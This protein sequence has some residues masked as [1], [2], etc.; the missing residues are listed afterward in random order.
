MESGGLSLAILAADVA[1][2]VRLAGGVKRLSSSSRRPLPVMLTMAKVLAALDLS[3]SAC[4]I[5]R[6]HRF[7]PA[8]AHELLERH[9]VVCRVSDGWLG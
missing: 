5:A 3:R 2:L 6:Q 1:E 7:D 8:D 4:R 9:R